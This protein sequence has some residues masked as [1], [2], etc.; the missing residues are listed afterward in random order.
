M[1]ASEYIHQPEKVILESLGEFVF[2]RPLGI[3][4]VIGIL[5]D[6]VLKNYN[7]KIDRYVGKFPSVEAQVEY[8]ERARDKEPEGDDLAEQALRL[9]GTEQGQL[10]LILRAIDLCNP[11]LEV[12]GEQLL[13]LIKDD[14]NFIKVCDIMFTTL[15]NT[16][17]VTKNTGKKS[18]ARSRKTKP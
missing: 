18:K 14:P 6:L 9:A 16:L 17:K 2:A 4:E 12:T 3:L 15:A 10:W 1:N 11:Q 5:S 8:I 7:D 13:E